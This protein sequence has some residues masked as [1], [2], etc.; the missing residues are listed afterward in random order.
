MFLVISS[1]L[2]TI[3]L[4]AMRF[5]KFLL[6]NICFCNSEFA[7]LQ[8]KDRTCRLVQSGICSG[9]RLILDGRQIVVCF[10]SLFIFSERQTCTKAIS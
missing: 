4:K 3:W 9:A 1:L 2:D 5:S 7:L 10:P 8:V 6:D